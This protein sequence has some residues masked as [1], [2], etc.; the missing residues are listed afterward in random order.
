MLEGQCEFL[1][2]PFFTL[3]F[4]HPLRPELL[5]CSIRISLYLS[6]NTVRVLP[7]LSLDLGVELLEAIS[8]CIL[9]SGSPLA[10]LTLKAIVSF[11][12]QDAHML[13]NVDTEDTVSMDL[14]IIF[15]LVVSL[16]KSWEAPLLVGD[17]E[18]SVTSTLKA[19]KHSVTGGC[20]HQSD[21]EDS[22]EW[23][24]VLFVLRNIVKSSV[25]L[26]DSLV[27]VVHVELLKQ[28]AGQ[29]KTCAVS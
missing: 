25:D 1:L 6:L 23:P 24:S 2:G 3:W 27:S 8:S 11:L 10:E 22:L 17:V 9:K 26:V 28:T 14:G 7:D 16:L 20:V 12:L 29:Q 21:I 5:M 19:A 4:A 13:V 15:A 18:S